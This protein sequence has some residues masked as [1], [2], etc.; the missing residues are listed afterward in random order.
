MSN[1]RQRRHA[2]RRATPSK[3]P[4]KTWSAPSAARRR[5]RHGRVIIAVIAL[6]FALLI[7]LALYR[8]FVE[9]PV[10]IDEP[11]PAGTDVSLI[12]MAEGDSSAL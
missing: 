2:S 5:E 3:A 6:T 1:R 12:W 8:V 4:R 7:S 9:G 11:E 10:D